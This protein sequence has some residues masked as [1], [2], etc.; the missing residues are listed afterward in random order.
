MAAS[1]AQPFPEHCL[2]CNLSAGKASSSGESGLEISLGAPQFFLH[3]T[4]KAAERVLIGAAVNLYR[5]GKQENQTAKVVSVS[6]PGADGNVEVLCRDD[7]GETRVIGS[8]QDWKIRMQSKQYDTCVPLE[9][10]R[11]GSAN[12]YYVLVL[13]EKQTILGVQLAAEK[14]SVDLIAHDGSHAAIEGNLTGEEKLIT[15]CSKEVQDG[16]LVVE[17]EGE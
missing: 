9:A 7:S 10:L 1:Y 4:A 2:S 12:E 15:A 3:I 16:D 14:V 8:E 13:T 5:D 6:T 17:N 11:Q